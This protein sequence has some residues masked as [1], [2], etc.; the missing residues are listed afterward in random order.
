MR[1]G[2]RGQSLVEFA[3]ILP[4]LLTLLGAAVDVS[5]VYGAWIALEGATRDAAEQV[6][7]DT[8][9][10]TQAGAATRAQAIV[11]AQMSSVPGFVAPAGNPALC[12]TP[13][14]TV[15]WTSST[16][17]PGT[18]RNPLVT[19]SVVSALP[20]RT[21]FAYP[22]LTQN[23]AWTVRSTHTYLILQGR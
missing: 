18:A 14:L 9:V 6:A 17:S 21:A 10:T 12:T 4:I 2:N 8:A 15:T 19:V 11:C 7:T 3:L 16:A 20:F 22:L 23:G 1:S 5:R 13:S